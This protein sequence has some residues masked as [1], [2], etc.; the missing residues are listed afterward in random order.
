MK[1]S[2]GCSGDPGLAGVVGVVGRLGA[3]DGVEDVAAAAGDAHDG[4]VV[5]F[6]RPRV[7]RTGRS[8]CGT[9]F[10]CGECFQRGAIPY[11]GMQSLTIVEDFD[12]FRNSVVR[13]L[14]G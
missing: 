11:A 12:V 4:G 14:A 1:L 8:G 10:V 2:R 13:F 3:E 9:C 7:F 6:G 5:A